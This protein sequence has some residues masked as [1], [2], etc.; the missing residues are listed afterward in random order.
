MRTKGTWKK[1]HVGRGKLHQ[2]QQW[3]QII[4][5]IA[6]DAMEDTGAMKEQQGALKKEIVIGS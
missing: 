4:I 5:N 6:R 2:E 1:D 3:P